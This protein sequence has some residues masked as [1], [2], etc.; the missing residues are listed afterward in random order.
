MSVCSQSAPGDLCSL[1]FDHSVQNDFDV[2]ELFK[3]SFGSKIFSNYD[4]LTNTVRQFE[5]NTRTRFI[6]RSCRKRIP[7][8]DLLYDTISFRC[9]HYDVKRKSSSLGFRR[10]RTRSLLY[11]PVR[12]F[13]RA[14]SEG[15]IVTSFFMQ[16]NH[17][18]SCDLPDW[19]R[20]GNQLR[21]GQI[22][23]PPAYACLKRLKDCIRRELVTKDHKTRRRCVVS[24]STSPSSDFLTPE[25]AHHCTSD[26][27]PTV[28]A[29]FRLFEAGYERRDPERLIS[30][31]DSLIKRFYSQHKS[32]SDALR[33]GGSKLSDAVRD[34][35]CTFC[36]SLAYRDM[37]VCRLCSWRAHSK[38]AGRAGVCGTCPRCPLDSALVHVKNIPGVD[39]GGAF[40]K[41]PQNPTARRETASYKHPQYNPS[42][43]SGLVPSITESRASDSITEASAPNSTLRS[44]LHSLS[45]RQTTPYL[46]AAETVGKEPLPR[47][48][49]SV[50]PVAQPDPLSTLR[51]LL[52]S[53]HY[54]PTPSLR[55][56]TPIT[57]SLAMKSSTQY[58]SSTSAHPIQRR[59]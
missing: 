23:K 55:P 42:G 35:V 15:L 54:V 44:L 8:D 17:P 19:K 57:S 22:T 28:L 5:Q 40:S 24:S 26:P 59:K 13:V 21:L 39:I 31:L 36:F 10:T 46:Q 1:N 49:S 48:S 33:L 30:Q 25:L 41:Q 18:L 50:P 20:I 27:L 2:S 12:F 4:E 6:I 29:R 52:T 3:A 43:F 16:H 14:T 7:L 9:Q 32:A 11:C 38:C 34:V 56:N 47:S 58:I 53:N 51:S 45:A 37:F